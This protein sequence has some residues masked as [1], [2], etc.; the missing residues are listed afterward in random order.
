[1]STLAIAKNNSENFDPLVD[2]QPCSLLPVLL[3]AAKKQQE[4][5]LFAVVAR[6]GYQNF[7]K[8]GSTPP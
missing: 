6:A 7:P 8:G 3:A 1:V 4:L 2:I 5:V